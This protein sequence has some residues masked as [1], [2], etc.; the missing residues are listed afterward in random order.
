MI[1][2][3]ACQSELLLTPVIGFQF[4]NFSS[5]AERF[6]YF[7][8]SIFETYGNSPVGIQGIYRSSHRLLDF[9]FTISQIATYG[10]KSAQS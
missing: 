2:V 8:F 6:P 4:Y 7:P 9:T 1:V 5:A 10:R 3:Q